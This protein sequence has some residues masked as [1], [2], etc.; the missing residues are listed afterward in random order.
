MH[1]IHRGNLIE[2]LWRWRLAKSECAQNG[3][4]VH[5]LGFI[6]LFAVLSWHH[7]TT[8]NSC[9]PSLG[10]EPPF[11]QKSTPEIEA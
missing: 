8:I 10:V 7:L 2:G 5:I 1:D 3:A 4:I 11:L 9:M 6:Q